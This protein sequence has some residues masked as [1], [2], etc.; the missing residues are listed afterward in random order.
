MPSSTSLNHT[1]VIRPGALGDSILTLPVVHELRLAR[2]ENILVL[3]TLPSW[4][5]VRHSHDGLRIR[6]FSSSEWLG[7]F[8]SD[9]KLGD[10]ARAAVSKVQT[11]IVYLNGDTVPTVQA[12]KAAG[13]QTVLCGLPPHKRIPMGQRP[14]QQLLAALGPVV[15]E[16]HITAALEIDHFAADPFLKM[17]D[18]ERSRAQ[19]YAIGCDAAGTRLC[20]DPSRQRRAAQNAGRPIGSRSWR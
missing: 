10:C 20:G 18:N 8:G 19:L 9:V 16:E 3:G 4:A 2:A 5:F 11:A 13:I 6:D 7:L 1:L 14:P 15:A 12:L 17:D